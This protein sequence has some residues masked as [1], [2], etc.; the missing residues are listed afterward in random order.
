MARNRK[1]TIDALPKSRAKE[2]CGEELWR[3][4]EELRGSF[5]E[6]DAQKDTYFRFLVTQM[7]RPHGKT[8]R[9][10]CCISC[11][12]FATKSNMGEGKA[13]QCS[14]YFTMADIVGR[15]NSDAVKAREYFEECFIE[16][17]WSALSKL[18]LVKKLTNRDKTELVYK[19]LLISASCVEPESSSHHSTVCLSEKPEPKKMQCTEVEDF[20]GEQTLISSKAA[21]H[22]L[23]PASAGR[24]SQH[25]LQSKS[26]PADDLNSGSL[27]KRDLLCLLESIKEEVATTKSLV[28]EAVK[29]WDGAGARRATEDRDSEKKWPGL[30]PEPSHSPKLENNSSSRWFGLERYRPPTTPWSAEQAAAR[31]GLMIGRWRRDG[32]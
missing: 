18:G 14:E 32:Y 26:P 9:Y 31:V 25:D 7:K 6:T 4:V 15:A 21:R 30:R 12:Q 23:I 22:P 13:H 29:K 1:V 11:Y 8:T 19:P 3:A 20:Y 2:E 17:N 24:V 5:M 28:L 10:L 27:S 16:A